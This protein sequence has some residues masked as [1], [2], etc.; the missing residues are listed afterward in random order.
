MDILLVWL[1]FVF[2]FFLHKLWSRAIVQTLSALMLNARSHSNRT[3]FSFVVS[4]KKVKAFC[5]SENCQGIYRYM[6]ITVYLHEVMSLLAVCGNGT[7]PSESLVINSSAVCC[8]A[9]P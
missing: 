2:C 4:V 7:L 1:F 3:G 6:C 9:G 8:C 5:N